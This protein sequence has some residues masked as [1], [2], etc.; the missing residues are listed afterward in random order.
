MVAGAVTDT[1][2][3]HASVPFKK[4]SHGC[5]GP[6][7]RRHVAPLPKRPAEWEPARKKNSKNNKKT[8]G[9][10]ACPRNRISDTI[11]RRFSADPVHAHRG[12]QLSGSTY[13]HTHTP[14]HTGRGASRSRGESLVANLDAVGAAFLDSEYYRSPLP[15][16][17]R[18]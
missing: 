18:E 13:T 4:R 9:G 17:V 2:T 12:V 8:L 16:S 5:S 14:V 3:A 6:C 7:Q 11:I 1:C 15:H 10:R